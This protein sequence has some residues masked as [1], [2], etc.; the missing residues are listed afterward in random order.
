MTGDLP[1]KKKKQ[2]YAELPPDKA[3][4][5]KDLRDQWEHGL[6]IGPYV[7]VLFS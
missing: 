2:K 4:G 7:G 5:W 6:K 3:S 1:S